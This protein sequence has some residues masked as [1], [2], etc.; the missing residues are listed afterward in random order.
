MIIDKLTLIT[1]SP[2]YVEELNLT[3]YQPKLKEIAFIGE[4]KFYSGLGS[5]YVSKDILGIE[6]VEN[7]ITDFDIFL[8]LAKG[9]KEFR[10]SVEHVFQLIFAELQEVIFLD[11]CL[12]FKFEPGQET[13]IKSKD[14]SLLKEVVGQIFMLKTQSS[15]L[16]PANDA[17]KK[18]AE[19]IKKRQQQLSKQDKSDANLSDFVS[20]LSTGSYSN[21][22]KDLEDFTIYQLFSAFERFNLYE[23]YRNQIQAIMQGAEN[24]ELVDW[25]K[26]L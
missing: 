14:F 16:N 12:I 3:F 24:I 8:Q 7:L 22:L 17:A 25:Y 6:D 21:S 26:K 5:I 11:D 20:I 2:F 15:D 9:I 4:K 18:I 19:K 10:F 1:G 13:I 23:Q